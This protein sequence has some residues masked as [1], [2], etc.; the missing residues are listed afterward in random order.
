MS[1]LFGGA[2]SADIPSSFIDASDFRPIPSHQEVYVSKDSS[3]SIIVEIVE[4]QP[5]PIENMAEYHLKEVCDSLSDVVIENGISNRIGAVGALGY[6]S[7]KDQMILHMI[8]LRLEKQSTDILISWNSTE[9]RSS[10]VKDLTSTLIV[11]DFSLF[12]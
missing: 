11:R 4:M 9:N 7:I 5:V 3:D 12:S 2:I 1:D 6:G 8:V 10:Q